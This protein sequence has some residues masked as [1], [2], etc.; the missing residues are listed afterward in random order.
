[1]I[2][3]NKII[4]LEQSIL[5]K[6]RYIL[7]RLSLDPVNVHELFSYVKDKFADVN[8]FVL[9]LDVLFSL[10]LVEITEKYEV[11]KNA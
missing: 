2:I 8:E 10:N 4:S 3:P 1:M 11:Y 5:G 6:S 7:G 9:A